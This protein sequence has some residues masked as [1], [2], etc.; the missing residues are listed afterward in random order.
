M[1]TLL[2]NTECQK[3]LVLRSFSLGLCN[4]LL[5]DGNSLALPLQCKRGHQSLDLGCL[6]PLLACGRDKCA[7]VRVNI[8]PH[9]ILLGKVEELAN[10]GCSFRTP[11]PWLLSISEA[12]KVIVTL[13]DNDK[14]QH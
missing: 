7:A 13:L 6:A 5:L 12:G 1:F 9:I 8:F 3:L 4:S 11:H 14:I 2:L 10:L